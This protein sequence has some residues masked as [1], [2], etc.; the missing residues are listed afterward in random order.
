MARKT[1]REK[2]NFKKLSKLEKKS[3][4][5]KK[6]IYTVKKGII[7]TNQIKLN[8]KL[9]EII[10]SKYTLILASYSLKNYQ[11]KNMAKYIGVLFQ[12]KSYTYCSLQIY[13]LTIFRHESLV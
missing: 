5:F 7:F 2:N 10:L 9:E 12:R 13:F 6:K 4:I 3:F 8:R 11:L 1:L